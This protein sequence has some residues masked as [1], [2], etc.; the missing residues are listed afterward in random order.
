MAVAG[1]ARAEKEDC[2]KSSNPIIFPTPHS[3]NVTHWALLKINNWEEV[4]LFGQVESGDKIENCG[5]FMLTGF[6]L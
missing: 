4:E 3:A 5:L 1:K 2:N 6:H